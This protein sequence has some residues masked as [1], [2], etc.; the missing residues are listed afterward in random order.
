MPSK[1]TGPYE[2]KEKLSDYVVDTPGHKR[3]SRV[4]HINMLKA[5]VTHSNSETKTPVVT[6]APVNVLR[7]E[8]SPEIYGLK[9]NSATFST[10]RM[11]NPETLLKLFS[12]IVAP[13][14]VC[15]G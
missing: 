9:M 10:T 3:K 15:P 13:V 6:V 12:K 5:Y 14:Y 2:I 11:H 4:C 1:F 8:Y 7:S